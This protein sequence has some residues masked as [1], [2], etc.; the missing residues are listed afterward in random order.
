MYCL[1][2][3]Q[4]CFVSFKNAGQARG[5]LEKKNVVKWLFGDDFL[6][7]EELAEVSVVIEGV[8]S[9]IFWFELVGFFIYNQKASVVLTFY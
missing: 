4:F 2:T 5:F 3:K 9:P 8:F 1:I 7:P 6:D